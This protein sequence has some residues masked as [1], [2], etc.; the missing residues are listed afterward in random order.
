MEALSLDG[1]MLARLVEKTTGATRVA[2]S[3]WTVSRI[4]SG[5]GEA[6]GVYR[7]SGS[8]NAGHAGV[9]PWSVVLKILQREADAREASRWNYSQREVQA[10]GSGFLEQLSGGLTAPRCLQIESHADGNTWLWL[11]D[12]DR[13]TGP[14]WPL[15]RYGL[16][17]YHLGKFNGTY[18]A[19]GAGDALPTYPWLSQ[20]WLRGWIDEASPFIS[21]LRRHRTHPLVRQMYDVDHVLE[22]W[23]DRDTRLGYLEKLPQTLCHLDAYRSNLFARRE[24]NGREQTVA[25]DW[26]FVGQAAFGEELASLVAATVAM[27]HVEPE[28]LKDLEATVLEGYLD[29]L[30]EEGCRVDQQV[31]KDAYAI[32]V[33]MRLPVGAIRLVLPLILDPSH[34]Q[35]ILQQEPETPLDMLC[36]RWGA[37][38]RHLKVLGQVTPTNNPF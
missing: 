10:Y 27:G 18:G 38:N 21:S 5:G 31:V 15:A 25:I 23:K 8:A 14:A 3:N 28:K 22:L 4:S 37:M 17:A 34:N 26:A 32:S 11:E 30:S 29:G 7:I 13:E 6:A 33:S 1:R 20:R 12:V 2:V 19:Y 16:A 36:Q 24:A 35:R 9:S